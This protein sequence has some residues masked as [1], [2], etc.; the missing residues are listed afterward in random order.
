MLFF[1]QVFPCEGCRRCN[2]KW[3]VKERPNVGTYQLGNLFSSF[4]SFPLWICQITFIGTKSARDKNKCI[5][6]VNLIKMY[7]DAV[8]MHLNQIHIYDGH[9]FYERK[10]NIYS[11]IY[12]KIEANLSIIHQLWQN[13]RLIFFIS[14]I[15]LILYMFLTIRFSAGSQAWLKYISVV[16]EV[17]AH[18]FF[19]HICMFLSVFHLHPA[20]QIFTRF[21]VYASCFQLSHY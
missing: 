6:N 10:I 5:L 12:K 13:I 1:S 3:R 17:H 9:Q 15:V 19:L 7:N 18:T 8:N 2:R 20:S 21:H 14:L 4:F 11:K 16:W